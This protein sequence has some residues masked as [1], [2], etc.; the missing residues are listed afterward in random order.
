MNET[1]TAEDDQERN[2]PPGVKAAKGH[3]KKKMAER[4]ALSEFQDMWSIKKE[5]MAMKERLS[6]M[7]PLDSLLAKQVPLAEYEEALKKK[8]INELLLN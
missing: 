8:L 6:K 5:D 1:T 2:R 7:K 4:K 3:D